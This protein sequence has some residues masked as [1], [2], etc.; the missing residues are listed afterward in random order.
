LKINKFFVYG[1]KKSKLQVAI[2]ERRWAEVNDGVRFWEWG[3]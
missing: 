3:C 1:V 2:G